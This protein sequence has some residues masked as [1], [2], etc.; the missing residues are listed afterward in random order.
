[1]WSTSSSSFDTPRQ[2]VVEGESHVLGGELLPVVT[3]DPLIS[4]AP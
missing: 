1:M 4:N 2:D 3:F